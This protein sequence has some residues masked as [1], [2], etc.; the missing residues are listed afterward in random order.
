MYSFF[1]LGGAV[2]VNLCNIKWTESK[3][4]KVSHYVWKNIILVSIVKLVN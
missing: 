4:K 2:L 1:F 3:R